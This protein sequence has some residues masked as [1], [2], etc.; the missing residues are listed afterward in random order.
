[1]LEISWP[2]K[3]FTSRVLGDLVTRVGI[4]KRFDVRKKTS[5]E[6]IFLKIDFKI[7]FFHFYKCYSQ[8]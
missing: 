8:R 7:S 2:G 3:E 1:M 5:S 4:H 6:S